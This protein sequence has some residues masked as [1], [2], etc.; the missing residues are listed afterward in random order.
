[1][2]FAASPRK[3]FASRYRLTHMST[4]GCRSFLAHLL[5]RCN[6]IHRPNIP[7]ANSLCFACIYMCT[8]TNATDNATLLIVITAE[9]FKTSSFELSRKNCTSAIPSISTF[10]YERICHSWRVFNNNSNFNKVTSSV[11]EVFRD[12]RL[13]L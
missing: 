3:A 5:H 10:Y 8:F 4:S 9:L 7:L 1:M 2:Q 12:V 6:G 11:S 13:M